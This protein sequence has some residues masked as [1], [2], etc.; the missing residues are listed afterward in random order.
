MNVQYQSHVQD[1]GWQTAVTNGQ[2][3]G[4]TGLSKR[5]EAL[6]LI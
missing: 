3:A 2:V 5:M 4:T 6:K 1:I